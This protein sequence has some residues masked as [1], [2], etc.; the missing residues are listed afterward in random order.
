MDAD[1]SGHAQAVSATSP[2]DYPSSV[3]PDGDA[4]VVTH[5]AADTAADIDVVSLRGQVPRQSLV[6]TPSYEGGSQFSPDGRWMAYA[7]D[8]SGQMQVYVRPFP[9]PDRKWPVSTQG[10]TSPRWNRNGTELFYRT[11]NKMMAVDVSIK[12]ELRLS[13]PRLL[14]EQRYAF[15]VNV[16]RANYDVSADGQRFVMVKDE[17]GSG[18][19]NVVLNLFEELKRLAPTGSK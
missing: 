1:G 12:P 16:A 10:G 18:R 9:G 14:F 19:L 4:L 17:S 2:D 6:K 7:S 8:E 5:I 13:P 11:G 3:A 15:G